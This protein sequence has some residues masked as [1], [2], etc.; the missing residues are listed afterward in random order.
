MIDLYIVSHGRRES[1]EIPIR[2]LCSVLSSRAPNEV[3]MQWHKLGRV[4]KKAELPLKVHV[5]QVT[6][7]RDS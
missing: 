3:R 1:G 2:L 4:L 5:L 6:Q 7:P